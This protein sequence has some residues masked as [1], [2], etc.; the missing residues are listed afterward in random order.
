MQFIYITFQIGYYKRI[1]AGIY[2]HGAYFRR[3]RLGEHG[4][5]LCRVGVIERYEPCSGLIH[6]VEL[7]K[8]F[9]H[10]FNSFERGRRILDYKR[11]GFFIHYNIACR[12]F[13]VD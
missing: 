1:S 8:G 11:I 13:C 4:F 2:F 6:A 10:L 5:D 12:R 3:Q 7:F 9:D